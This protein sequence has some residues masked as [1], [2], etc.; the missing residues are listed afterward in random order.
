MPRRLTDIQLVKEVENLTPQSDQRIV[1]GLILQICTRIKN[2]TSVPPASKA[3]YDYRT[4]NYV[5]LELWR[6]T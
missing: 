5:M 2:E 4:W 3:G 6:N 1:E